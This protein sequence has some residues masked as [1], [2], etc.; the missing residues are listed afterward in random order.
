[1]Q[2][3]LQ[4][5][6]QGYMPVTNVLIVE[7]HRCELTDLTVLNRVM[8]KSPSLPGTTPRNTNAKKKLIN[9]K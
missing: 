1:M 4:L 3:E 9:P 5:L 6:Y 8:K 7:K 2:I